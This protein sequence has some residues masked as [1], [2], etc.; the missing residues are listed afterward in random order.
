[1]A[2]AYPKTGNMVSC[3]LSDGTGSPV[4]YA[5]DSDTGITLGEIKPGLRNH[6]VIQRK[7][8]FVS[9]AFTDA[10]GASLSM[11]F[12]FD[13]F[14][15]ASGGTI[16]DYIF[17]DGAFSA[18]IGTL[19]PSGS[20]DLKIPFA[21]DVILAVEG[22]DYGDSADGTLTM[23]D[24]IISS[25]SWSAAENEVIKVTVTGEVWGAFEGDIAIARAA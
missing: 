6:T 22:T 12:L 21:C 11:D 17:K 24:W 18:R 3:T 7:G 2:L 23:R 9:V 13:N 8:Q 4:T 15:K 10:L 14:S 5:V 1:M 20:T 16:L 25:V 19:N